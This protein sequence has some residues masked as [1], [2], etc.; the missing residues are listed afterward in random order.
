[1]N[2]MI[3]SHVPASNAYTA[4]LVLKRFALELKEEHNL[5]FSCIAPDSIKKME[6]A[7]ELKDSPYL[8]L[9][10]PKEYGCHPRKLWKLR[11]LIS[12]IFNLISLFKIK[13]TIQTKLNDFIDKHEVDAVLVLMESM[14]TIEIAKGLA[15]KKNLKVFSLCTDHISWY[16]NDVGVDK[17]SKNRTLG[18]YNFLIKKSER[19]IVPSVEMKEMFKESLMKESEVISNVVES[20]PCSVKNK[21]NEKQIKIGFAGQVYAKDAWNAFVESLAEM[22]WMINGKEVIIY[23]FGREIPIAKSRLNIKHFGFGSEKQVFETLREMDYLYCP[24]PF[25]IKLSH[26]YKYSFPSKLAGYYATGVPVIAHAPSDS[27]IANYSNKHNSSLLLTTIEKT[28]V[29]TFLSE[30]DEMNK[31]RYTKISQNSLESVIRD[32][33][34]SSFKKKVNFVFRSV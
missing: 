33:S 12:F 13:K 23:F 14:S 31:E 27:S 8:S 18:N 30:L 29:K 6:L 24:Y 25:D 16:L 32:F 11:K 9:S 19:V 34:K 22:G 20:E 28:E 10:Q 15:I 2:I 3:L 5:S 4:G 21:K 7:D 26:V 17:W 1:M